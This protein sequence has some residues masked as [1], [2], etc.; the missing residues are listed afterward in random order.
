MANSLLDRRATQG[1]WPEGVANH[2]AD[3]AIE[4]GKKACQ[5]GFTQ[6]ERNSH[7]MA[8]ALAVQTAQRQDTGQAKEALGTR[9]G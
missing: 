2:L 6:V 3:S 5:R 7:K 1:N 8:A 9:L 4:L